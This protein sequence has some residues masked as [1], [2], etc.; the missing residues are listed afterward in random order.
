MVKR[1]FF[2][3]HGI[4]SQFFQFTCISCISMEFYRIRF[5]PVSTFMF[6]F[7]SKF[8]KLSDK[9]VNLLKST[10]YSSSQ[11]NSAATQKIFH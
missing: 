4:L 2:A 5:W 10:E 6:Q 1:Q 7:Q 9:T 11:Q 3:G 8:A